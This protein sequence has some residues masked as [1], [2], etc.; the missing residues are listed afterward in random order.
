MR[1]TPAAAA[2]LAALGGCSL[3]P[4]YARPTMPAPAP[5]AYKEAAGAWK[6]ATPAD[7]APRGPWWTRFGDSDLNDLEDQ[8]SSANQSLRAA[9][10]R[11][12]EARAE[13]RI[14]RASYFP[15]VAASATAN[16]E[17]VSKNTPSYQPGTSATSNLFTLGGNFSY[18]ADVFGRVRNTVANARYS[19]QATAGDVASLDLELHA[20]LA[21]D[22]F[23]LRGLDVEQ[24]LLD[25]TVADYAHA[26]QLTQN[27]YKGGASP[28]SDVQQAQAQLETALTQAEDTRLR[29]AQT[30]HA[31]AVLVG[32]EPS[33]FSIAAR[34][35]PSLPPLSGVDPGLPSQLLERRPDVAA[36]ERRVAAANANIGV[37]R[38]AFF[39]IFNLFASAGYQST[40]SSNWLTAPSQFWSLGPQAVLT[41]FN[42]GLYRAQ[43]AQAHA[44]YDEQ[45]AN[46]RGTVLTAYQDVEDNLVALRQL[47][48]E[49]VSEAAAVTANQGALEQANLRYKGGIVTYLEVVSTENAY[50]S[51][52]LSAV[53]IEIRRAGATVL[54]IRALGGDWQ[55]P[56]TAAAATAA[57]HPEPAG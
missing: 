29:R 16:R 5:D 46:Y 7:A 53:D 13:T 38:A 2:V 3:A 15:T 55:Q 40:M 9:L 6:V 1:A 41:L 4:H 23:T 35:A 18:E 22:Y 30:E 51:A 45:V 49:S 32:R 34:A 25:R 33:S 27:L 57:V 24:Q 21:T 50:L 42:G 11:L 26:L 47:Q 52:Q 37:A 44:A 28:I 56:T 17:R 20:E 19:E 48:L 39:P 12:D 31:I 8:V 54:L 14:A 10:A 43:S 36:A